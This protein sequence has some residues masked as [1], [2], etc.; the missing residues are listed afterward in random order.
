MIATPRVW[1]LISLVKFKNYPEPDILKSLINP[2]GCAKIL[3][4][5]K[6]I[7]SIVK[8]AVGT[9]TFAG[10]LCINHQ[11]LSEDSLLKKKETRFGRCFRL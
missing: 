11:T 4:A 5:T 1:N 6:E 7:D 3:I 8:Y 2:C 9:G 10:A